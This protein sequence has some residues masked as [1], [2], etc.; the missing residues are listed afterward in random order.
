MCYAI[1]VDSTICQKCLAYCM[2][3][4][5]LVTKLKATAAST[6]NVNIIVQRF[7][8]GYKWTYYSTTISIMAC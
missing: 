2:D 5:A 4:E 1:S 6:I 3:Y 8:A 7:L